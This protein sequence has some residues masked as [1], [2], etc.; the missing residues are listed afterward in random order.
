VRDI[1]RIALEPLSHEA[2]GCHN[3]RVGET[4]ERTCRGAEMSGAKTV[5]VGVIG[6]GFGARVVAPVFAETDG[7]KVVDV[8]SPRDEA[9]VRALC[10]RGDV[11]LV[12]VHSPPFLHADHVRWAVD[13]GHAVLCDKPFGRDAHEAA[14]IHDV[15]REA[16]VLHFANFEFR[17]HP[18]RERLRALVHEG[19]VGA[20]EHFQWT[21]FSA[22]SRLPLRRF[23]WLFDREL[24]GG[25]IGAL[26]SHMIDYLI[27]SL[28]S[29]VDAS[30]ELRTTIAERP[31][32]DGHLRRCTAEDAFTAWM[33]SEGGVTIVI[34]T[35]FAAPVNVP[36]VVT[37][38]G[39]D[40]VLELTADQRL[41]L[42]TDAGLKEQF[43]LERGG[44]DPHVLPMRRWA[45]KVR[46]AL[47]RESGA[48]DMPTLADGVACA[49][50]M[51]RLRG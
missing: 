28:G 18:A 41:T 27:W 23:G 36:T 30:A 48:P 14:V 31:D 12:S 17:C 11:D 39:A 24:G 46:D 10:A 43:V 3:R 9:A 19:A 49:R 7:C 50:V 4:C 47:R 35:T 16:G 2:P 1:Q 25:W 44:G 26:G 21:A 6:R 37:V 38:I 20:V 33:R 22:A 8:V 32:A 29:I 15:A 13:S 34:D 5:R 40:G 45:E 42:R 51:D